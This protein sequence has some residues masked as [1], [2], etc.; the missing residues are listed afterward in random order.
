MSISATTDMIRSRRG[1]GE[2]TFRG[3][4]RCLRSTSYN[5]GGGV[6]TSSRAVCWSG[7]PDVSGRKRS[8]LRGGRAREQHFSDRWTQGDH[9]MR[10][11]SVTKRSLPVARDVTCLDAWRRAD[12]EKQR[13][14][15]ASAVGSVCRSDAD[16]AGIPSCRYRHP[17]LAQALQLPP[18]LSHPLWHDMITVPRM[19]AGTTTVNHVAKPAPFPRLPYSSLGGVDPVCHSTPPFRRVAASDVGRTW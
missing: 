10:H 5:T 6:T 7:R 16:P 15:G 2:L 8:K 11:S 19:L 12:A 13:Q 9:G 14:G 3:C 1:R 17:Q 4:G 18:P